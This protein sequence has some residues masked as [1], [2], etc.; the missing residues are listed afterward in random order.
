[1]RLCRGYEA[2]SEIW[3][4][5]GDMRLCRGC[6]AV[7]EMWGCVGDVRLCRGY[8]AVSGIG[9]VGDMRLCRGCEAVSGMWG[10]VGDVR[11]CRRYEAV[12][13]I[14]GCVG[15]KLCRRYE[16]VSGIWCCVGDMRLCRPQCQSGL[17]CE[18]EIP[19]C[20]KLNP[21]HPSHTP[22]TVLSGIA[23]LKFLIASRFLKHLKERRVTS[24]SWTSLRSFSVPATHHTF[25]FIAM[26]YDS[27]P[28]WSNASTDLN[29][30]IIEG[31]SKVPVHTHVLGSARD[32]R[33]SL[34]FL[35]LTNTCWNLL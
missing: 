25:S 6:E 17:C 31:D 21:G 4:C 29:T 3:G 2:V 35:T 27:H 16:A 19:P 8:E 20:Q 9:C 28:L 10:C 32:L 1:M 23:N 33:V 13:G 5:V 7:S 30:L 18:K 11:L 24:Y 26:L 15:D 34:D 12:S 22:V 14:W